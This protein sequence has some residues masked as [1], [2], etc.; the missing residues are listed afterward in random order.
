LTG[1]PGCIRLAIEDDGVGFDPEAAEGSG[2]Q[3]LRNIRERAEKIDARCC[4][5]SSPGQG[6]TVTIEVMK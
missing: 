4:I 2:G 1:E 3:G 6:T 5:E